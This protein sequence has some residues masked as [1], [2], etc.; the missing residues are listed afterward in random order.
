MKNDWE[1]DEWA[2][3]TEKLKIIELNAN[4]EVFIKELKEESG[5]PEFYDPIKD[6]KH[7]K[8]A[9]A[10]YGIMRKVL[11]CPSCFTSVSFDS[12]ADGEIFIASE[13][14]HTK[15]GEKLHKS[16][17]ETFLSVTC[18][19]CSCTL[20]VM[21]PSSHLFHLFHVLEGNF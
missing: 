1:I 10:K 15:I 6:L 11:S 20:G 5:L 3:N 19:V 14:F 2:P 18:E 16:E 12:K 7:A 21:D 13:T 4:D 17:N 8:W 9:E